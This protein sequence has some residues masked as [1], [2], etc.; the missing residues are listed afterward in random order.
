MSALRSSSYLRILRRLALAGVCVGG[1]S[2]SGAPQTARVL[3]VA[4]GRVADLVVLG[5]GFRSGLRVGMVARVTR[6]GAPVGELVIVD[7]RE[8]AASALI[9]SLSPERV[10]RQ[11][12]I[13]S[14]KVFKSQSS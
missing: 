8:S 7:L 1:W 5:G 10:V 12:D 4:S 3:E 6:E 11:G 14:V 9:V 13:T 2:A